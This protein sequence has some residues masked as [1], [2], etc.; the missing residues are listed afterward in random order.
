[1][2][3]QGRSTTS[4]VAVRRMRRLLVGAQ[5]AIATPLLVVAG[6]L[7]TSL[8]Q[9]ARV[10]LGFDT[11]N[12]ITGGLLLPDARYRDEGQMAAFWDRLQERVE[13]IPGVAGVTFS[14]G[15]P[16]NDVGSFN[17]FDLEDA[18]TPPG[19]SQ[20]VTP[21]VGVTPDYFKLFGLTLQEGRLFDERDG[22]R[23]NI[24]YIVVDRAWARRF[25]PNGS[26]LGKRLKEGGCTTCRWTTVIGVVSDVKYAGIDKPDEG[27]VYWPMPGRG[28][29]PAEGSGTRFRNLV[30]RTS[31]DPARVL[32]A[33]R[34]T[35]H[36]LDPG[37][38]F[39]TQTIDDLVAEALQQP[40]SLSLLVAGFALVALVLSIVGIYGVMAYY[41]QQHAKDISIR[42]ALGGT[43]SGVLRLI[44]GQGMTVVAGGVAIGLVAAFLLVRLLST[45]LFGIGARDA[46]T[47]AAVTSLLL[48]VALAACCIPAGRAVATEPAAVLRNE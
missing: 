19:Q 22:N 42:L 33:L 8:N 24:E 28:V 29:A 30:V 47:F 18:P 38:P 15:R 21:W 27:S 44:V 2:R 5:F 48:G 3:A 45:L 41:V 7:L 46:W 1:M 36:D 35:V 12:L 34:Q 26:A 16:P 20:P 4:S 10:D 25:F 31:T 17:N 32:P 43:Q 40:R 6:L 9:L 39:T 37:L 23:S 13:A 14:D 11:H